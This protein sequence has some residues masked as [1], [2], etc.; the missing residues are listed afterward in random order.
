MQ[1]ASITAIESFAYIYLH[2]VKSYALHLFPHILP[3]FMF[4]V[5]RPVSPLGVPSDGWRKCGTH[6]A[7]TEITYS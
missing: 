7:V 2:I 6:Q 3:V 4:G 1:L 5:L